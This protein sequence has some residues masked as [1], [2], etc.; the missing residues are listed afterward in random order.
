MV[1]DARCAPQDLIKMEVGPGT[2]TVTLQSITYFVSVFRLLY[3]V[4]TRCL[5]LSKRKL[6]KGSGIIRAF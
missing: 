2:H 3:H 4:T 6:Y 5:L 1:L